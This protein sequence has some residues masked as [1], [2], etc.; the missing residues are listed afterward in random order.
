MERE[1]PREGDRMSK[2]PG[3]AVRPRGGSERYAAFLRG[4]MPTNA[5]M[6]DLKRSFELAGFTDVKTV[7]S[8]G[9]VVFSAPAGLPASELERRAEESMRKHL[10]Q[11]FLTIVR[12]V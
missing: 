3:K 5:K 11:P 2:Q 9:N 4:V 8:S 10:K 6:P 7:L 12:S 1:T